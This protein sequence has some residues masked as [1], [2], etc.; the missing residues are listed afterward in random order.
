MSKVNQ[1][2]NVTIDGVRVRVFFATDDNIKTALV[3]LDGGTNKVIPHNKAT[4][5][6]AITSS[7]TSGQLTEALEG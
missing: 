3:M 1:V 5:I 4:K 6:A 2:N 7:F